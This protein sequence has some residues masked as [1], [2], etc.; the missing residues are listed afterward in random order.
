MEHLLD[1]PALH[2]S[3]TSPVAASLVEELLTLPLS[4]QQ[5]CSLSHWSCFLSL[6]LALASP[7]CRGSL[8]CASQN[9]KMAHLLC[10][11]L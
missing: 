4:V 9:G 5:W 6:L 7:G 8:M 2:R 11:G 3:G 10:A 1:A